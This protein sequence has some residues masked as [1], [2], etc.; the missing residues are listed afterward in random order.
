MD[1]L[2]L[3]SGVLFWSVAATL[4]AATLRACRLRDRKG[5]AIQCSRLS[6]GVRDSSGASLNRENTSYLAMLERLLLISLCSNDYFSSSTAA[7][8]AARRAIGTR[9]GE[10]EA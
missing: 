3:F 1:A 7:C 10:Q 6:L 4:Y 8:A 2:S 9:N 5:R